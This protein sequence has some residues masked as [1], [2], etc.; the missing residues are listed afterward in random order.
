M[1]GSLDKVGLFF[2]P[3]SKVG[4]Q[5]QNITYRQYHNLVLQ[6]AKSFIKVSRTC[7]LDMVALNLRRL[8][9]AKIWWH[10]IS[11]WITVR[12]VGMSANG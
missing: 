10:A 6:A 12:C 5:W 7:L 8:S 2:L 1:S 11:N 3:A 9:D 4:D